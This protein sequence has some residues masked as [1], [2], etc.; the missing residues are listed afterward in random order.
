MRK[1]FKFKLYNHQKR[2][3]NLLQQVR[4][5]AGIYNHF[6]ALNKRYFK[7][8]G[9]SLSLYQAQKHLT[10]LKKLEKYSWMRKL[11]SQASQEVL[12]RIDKGFKKFFRDLKSGIKTSP[13]KFKA[14]RKYKSFTLKQAGYRLL[15]DN[16]IKIGK[17]V[18]KFWKSRE[19]EGEIKT[20]TIKR[21]PVGDWFLIFSCEVEEFKPIKSSSKTGK[22]AGFDFGLTTFLTNQDDEEIKSELCLK[23]SLKEL[24][25]KSKALSRKK[26]GSNN[27]AK[28]RLSLA[29]LHRK[30]SNQRRDAHFKL[31]KDLAESHDLM[32]FEDLNMKWMMKTHGRKA[33]DLGFAEFLSILEHQS[34]KYGALVHKIDRFYPSSH[35]C[36]KCLKKREK[37]LLLWERTWACTCGAGHK[38]DH[39]AAKNILREGASSLGLCD[40]KT[41]LRSA[42][43]N[44]R[45]PLLQ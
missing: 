26:K 12:E 28:A 40:G 2:N 3:E 21:D 27:R 16:Q 5:A 41:E 25:K 35:V 32:F 6:L 7:I 29:R 15:E 31:A 43:S 24:K 10:K 4:V 17:K 8:F 38:R 9:K 42:V 20:L 23:K 1:S 44:S 22:I 39:N 18:F 33:S 19:I 30:V 45:I 37:K 11:G 14:S 34:K 36:S 13:P